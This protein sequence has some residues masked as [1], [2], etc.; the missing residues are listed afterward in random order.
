MEYQVWVNGSYLPRSQA[1]LSF[2]DS[3]FRSSDVVF[4]TSRTFDGKI[5]RLGEHIERL[6]RSLRY[7]RID[8]G[9]SAGE[10]EALTRA[11]AERNGPNRPSGDDYFITQII[12]RGQGFRANLATD[13]TVA[14]W[15]D[16]ITWS[17]FAPLYRDG[18]H[19]IIP[20]TRAYAPDQVDPKIKHYNRLNFVL[21]ELEATDID[22]Q[23]FAL[24]LDQ[25]GN[26]A[27]AVNI[28]NFFVVTD[29]VLRTPS[30]RNVLQG[31][32]RQ[33][34]F[35]L[36]KDLGIRVI[37][38]DL[39]PYDV[40]TADEAFV[41]NSNHCICPVGRVDFRRIGLGVPGQVTGQ[42]LTAWSERVG[43]DIV[44]QIQTQAAKSAA[45]SAATATGVRVGG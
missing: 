3:G 31:I 12:T 13:P 18:V 22:P 23:A 19:L 20:K 14:I 32:S 17:I 33:T 8:P 28:G 16:P 27:E 24:L 38:E 45:S 29:G 4:D 9:Y 1:T 25:H 10:L 42:L 34:V 40:Y 7:L 44:Q 37:E 6:M 15:I 21:A 39:Q 2:M 26:V 36:A 43:L 11:V 5:Y 35:E 30:D 41:T